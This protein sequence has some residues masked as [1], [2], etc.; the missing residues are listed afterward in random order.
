VSRPG[1]PRKPVFG[2]PTFGL[3]GCFTFS[4]VIAVVAVLIVIAIKELF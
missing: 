1:P 2:I 3:I 4:I